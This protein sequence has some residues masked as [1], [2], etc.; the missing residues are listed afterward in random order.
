[1]RKLIAILC[2]TLLAAPGLALARDK[3]FMSSCLKG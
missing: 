2:C 3:G 1:M